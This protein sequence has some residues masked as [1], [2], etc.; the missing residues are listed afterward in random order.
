MD[1]VSSSSI[2]FEKL[3]DA[4]S[5]VTHRGSVVTMNCL[6]RHYLINYCPVLEHPAL[7]SA[8]S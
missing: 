5:L 3:V 2:A 4:A 6:A 1:Y 7:M 8:L